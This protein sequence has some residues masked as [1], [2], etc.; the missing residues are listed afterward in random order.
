MKRSAPQRFRL[1]AVLIILATIISSQS[2]VFAQETVT[3]KQPPV[4]TNTMKALLADQQPASERCAAGGNTLCR[5]LCR[6]L[7]L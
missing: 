1:L 5:W 2:A 3:D 6:R 4:L 7:S